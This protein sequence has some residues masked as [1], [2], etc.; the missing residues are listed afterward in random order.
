MEVTIPPHGTHGQH[1]QVVGNQQAGGSEGE[2]AFFAPPFPLWKAALG[3]LAMVPGRPQELPEECGG[4]EKVC[5]VQAAASLG[6][7]EASA[8]TVLLCFSMEFMV[9]SLPHSYTSV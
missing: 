4:K 6:L 9:N 2:K 8:C 1:A 3:R 5:T 7:A